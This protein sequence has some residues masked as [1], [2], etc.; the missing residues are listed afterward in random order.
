MAGTAESCVWT[1]PVPPAVAALSPADATALV[2]GS[3]F[4]RSM[5]VKD[6]EHGKRL[7]DH[8][9]LLFQPCMFCAEGM[10]AICDPTVEEMRA[11]AQAVLDFERGKR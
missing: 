11:N 7:C 6:P 5:K 4:A 3:T 8:G 9:H 10:P 1:I 2:K